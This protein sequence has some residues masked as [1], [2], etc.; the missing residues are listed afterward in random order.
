VT[1]E[2]PWGLRLPMMVLWVEKDKAGLRPRPQCVRVLG[3]AYAGPSRQELLAAAVN[4]TALAGSTPAHK[5]L[6][7]I[8]A[9]FCWH[10]DVSC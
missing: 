4:Q 8:S 5:L 9:D 1:V 2:L 7:P 10:D 3:H 6:V